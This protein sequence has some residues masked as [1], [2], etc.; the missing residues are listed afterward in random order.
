M[1]P[2]PWALARTTAV[3]LSLVLA[4]LLVCL[5]ASEGYLCLFHPVYEYAAPNPD[6]KR[7]KEAVVL[8][9]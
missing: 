9:G 1:R 4:S 7:P 5:A 6:S 3:N 2:G 8:I